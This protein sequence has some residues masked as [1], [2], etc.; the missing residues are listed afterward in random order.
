M[1]MVGDEKTES[2]KDRL[3]NNFFNFAEEIKTKL[4]SQDSDIFFDYIDPPSG[5][6]RHSQ[7]SSIYDEI[8][9]TEV[10]LRYSFQKVNG[11]RVLSHPEWGINCYP[12]AMFTNAPLDVVKALI[13]GL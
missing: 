5:L 10:L 13:D 12:A 11:C 3:L 9:A 6:P 4:A 2:E 8:S 7:S 1:K